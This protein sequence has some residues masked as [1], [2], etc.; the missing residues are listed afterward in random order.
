LQ[1]HILLRLALV[2]VC[3][4]I[5][6]GVSVH[7]SQT[8]QA[9]SVPCSTNH[10]TGIGYCGPWTSGL[11]NQINGWWYYVNGFG[12]CNTTYGQGGPENWQYGQTGGWSD[13][14]QWASPNF[15]QIGS[16]II[17][18]DDVDVEIWIG[19]EDAT[20]CAYG[21]VQDVNGK[22][23]YWLPEGANVGWYDLGGF[24]PNQ[25]GTGVFVSLT[26]QIDA[27]K[28]GS[29]NGGNLVAGSAVQMTAYGYIPGY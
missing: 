17:I 27:S 9:S 14:L 26:N 5:L 16:S 6:A 24:Q 21:W 19:S 20:S 8:V 29:G 7:T 23:Y 18:F 15:S 1:R 10:N 3:L 12:C 13:R 4:T 28:C 22:H 25:D 11:G 2:L